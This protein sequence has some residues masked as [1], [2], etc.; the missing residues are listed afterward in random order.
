MLKPLSLG[1]KDILTPEETIR[2]FG[3]SRRKFYRWLQKPHGFIAYFRK[4]K[5]ILRAELE[6]HFLRYPKEREAMING[7]PR[8]KT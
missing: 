3:L 6:K 1:K 8:T 2:Y 7:K 4:R 5:I